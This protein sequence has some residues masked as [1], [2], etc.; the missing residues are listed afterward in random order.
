MLSGVFAPFHCKCTAAVSR[1]ILM[2]WWGEIFTGVNHERVMSDVTYANFG[3][4]KGVDNAS[5]LG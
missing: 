1:R 3:W 4:A 5:R 2:R